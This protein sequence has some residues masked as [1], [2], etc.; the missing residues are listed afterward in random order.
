MN[1]LLIVQNNDNYLA[2]ICEDLQTNDLEKIYT[3]ENKLESF[4]FFKSF[5]FQ[6]GAKQNFITQKEEIDN[7]LANKKSNEFELD[8]ILKYNEKNQSIS[9]FIP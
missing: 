1:A 3:Q 6:L 4:S 2:V 7:F 5:V 9:F 8:L